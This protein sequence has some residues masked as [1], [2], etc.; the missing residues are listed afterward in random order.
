MDEKRVYLVMRFGVCDGA[1]HP[2]SVCQCM[3]EVSHVPIFIFELFQELNP[4]I[5]NRHTQAIIEATTSFPYRPAQDWHARY[6]L[7]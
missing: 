3:D 2:P 6:I 7:K 1:L 5:W 4:L